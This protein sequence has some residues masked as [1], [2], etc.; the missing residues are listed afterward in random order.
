MGEIHAL[1]VGVADALGAEAVG[2]V[3][4]R[5]D[6]GLVPGQRSQP[7][8]GASNEILGSDERKIGLVQEG[9]DHAADQPHIVVEGQ[10]THSTNGLGLVRK[11]FLELVENDLALNEKGS[12]REGDRLGGVRG[13]GGELHE[14]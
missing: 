1:Q 9:R 8:S 3:G 7:E 5:G 2:K 10:P 13:A 4:C 11:G 12:V 14:G 6:D